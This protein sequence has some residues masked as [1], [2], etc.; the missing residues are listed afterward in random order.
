MKNREVAMIA[1]L[2]IRSETEKDHTAITRVNDLAFGR[3]EEGRL[4]EKLRELDEFDPELSLVAELNGK[5]IGHALF[6]PVKI[7]SSPLGQ[8]AFSGMGTSLSL[9]PIAVIP[10]YQNLGIGG[11]LI[12][13]GH[14]VALGHGF[15]SVILLGHP[16]YYPRFGYQPADR[17]G[18][19]NPWNI[20]GEPWMAIELVEGAL[21]GKAGL[22]VYPEVFNEAT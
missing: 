20:S 4:V 8:E 2:I 16:G 21:T 11:Q 10:E 12:E 1:N 9:G 14:R 13:T 19:T 18:L 17:W 7:T 6:T 5:I 3:P 22:V 15:T